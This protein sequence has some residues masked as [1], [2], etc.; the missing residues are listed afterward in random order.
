MRILVIN[1]NTTPTMTAAIGE[2]ARAAARLGTEVEA[3]SPAWGPASI[4]GHAEEVVAAAAVLE[5]VARRGSDVDG[6]AIACYGDPG[7][8]AA[9]ELS[10]VPVVGIAESSMLLACTVAHRFSVV[11]VIDRIRPMLEDTVRRYGLSDRCASVRGTDL[12][13]LEIEKDPEA[14]TREIVDESRKAVT[15]DK[16][17]A[18]CLGCA[19]MGP[20][21]EDVRAALEGIPVIDGVAAAVKTL[22]SL[23]DLG[24]SS[25]R[26]AAFRFPEPKAF[27]GSGSLVQAMQE[28]IG[29]QF[30]PTTA[31]LGGAEW[32]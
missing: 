15:E 32:K 12:A 13:V 1:P 19:G 8:Y 30:V 25:S 29:R 4:E 9:R 3:L 10:P 27:A 17:E 20:L 21:E 22:E 23:V 2:R 11:T 5:V 14:A 26:R 24:L 16:A 28:R 6:I 18:I 31:A 7:L